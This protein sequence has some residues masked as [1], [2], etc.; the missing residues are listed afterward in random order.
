MLLLDTKINTL[1][2]VGRGDP[3]LYQHL[4][5]FFGHP[6]VYVLIIPAFGR[7]SHSVI[8]LSG[9][10]IVFGQ[11]R[12][13][14]A[15]VRIGVL[16]CVVWAHHIFTVGIDIDRRAYFT[17]ATIV[18]GIPTGI[19]VFSWLITLFGRKISKGPLLMWR[20]GFLFLFS[21]GGLTG[22]TLRSSSLDLVLHDS[23]FVV[24]HFHYV[25]SI[26]A[27]FGIIVSLIMWFPLVIGVTF[28]NLLL[29]VLFWTAFI[30]S[31]LVFFPQHFIGLNGLP[32]RY[33]EC[34][35]LFLTLNRWSSLG[36]VIRVFTL[37]TFVVVIYESL[38]AKRKVYILSTIDLH[39]MKYEHIELK[40]INFR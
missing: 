22:I 3:V 15:I 25:L 14:Y 31:N 38:V 12:I 40:T 11:I 28:N 29:S 8:C 18:I 32:R 20:L 39:L 19:K 36:S 27:M 1:F 13:I 35:D 23:Y 9:K 6:E 10:K 37:I 26:G 17:A 21:M 5:W 2:F 33:G 34:P 7:I 24:G 30:G 4:F 16:G